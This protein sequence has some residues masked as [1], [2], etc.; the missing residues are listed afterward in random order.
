LEDLKINAFN[1]N[2]DFI[3]K[4]NLVWINAK[5]DIIMKYKGLFVNYAL[6]DVKFVNNKI[7]YYVNWDILD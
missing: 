3:Y 4:I 7:V 5:R 6:K 2:K 1:V